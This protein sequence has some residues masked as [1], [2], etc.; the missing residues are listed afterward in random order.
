M[1]LGENYNLIIARLS[2]LSYSSLTSKLPEPKAL[3][4]GP[5]AQLVR[6]GRS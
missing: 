1:A 2:P 5:V 4:Q 6:A 3:F